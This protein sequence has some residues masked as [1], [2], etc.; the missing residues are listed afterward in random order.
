MK[1]DGDDPAAAVRGVFLAVVAMATIGFVVAWVAEGHIDDKMAAFLGVLWMYWVIAG[2]VRR[3]F[4][5]PIR[6]L[7]R[8]QLVGGVADGVPMITR[9]EEIA[10]LEKLAADPHADRH[11]ALVGGIRL[12]ELYRTALHDQAKSDA[13]LAQ[14]AARYPDA[15]ELAVARA[16][17]N[18]SHPTEI[19]LPGIDAVTASL[20]R[21]VDDPG[22]DAH[23]RIMGARRLAEIYRT[24]LNDPARAEALLTRLRARYPDES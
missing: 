17:G 19:P 7:M 1:L 16:W 11:R 21:L 2:D 20:E 15:P 3:V 9:D 14:L 13:L 22:T 24:H 10:Y 4:I 8:A 12:A 23:H 5:E 18:A 6:R